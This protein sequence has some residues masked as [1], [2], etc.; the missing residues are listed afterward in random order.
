MSLVLVCGVSVLRSYSH[1]DGAP[2]EA[3]SNAVPTQCRPLVRPCTRDDNT[4]TT[5][6][7]TR[8]NGPDYS[9]TRRAPCR[10]LF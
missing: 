1:P 10:E 8:R 4:P 5:S 9:D 7:A 3:K 2:Q 6:S